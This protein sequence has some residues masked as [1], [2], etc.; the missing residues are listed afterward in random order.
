MYL[1]TVLSSLSVPVYRLVSFQFEKRINGKGMGDGI[2]QHTHLANPH[3][4]DTLLGKRN[5]NELG[6]SS[7]T[8]AIDHRGPDPIP[9]SLSSNP[10]QRL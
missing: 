4:R 8:R 10:I 7:R 3:H 2:N 5:R 9:E 1:I 6:P